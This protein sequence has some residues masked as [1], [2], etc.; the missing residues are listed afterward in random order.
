[1]KGKIAHTQ[2]KVAGTVLGA[3]DGGPAHDFKFNE[4][5]SLSILCKDQAEIDHYWNMITAEGKA[6]QCGW[7]EDPFGVHWQVAP[8]NM[9]EL[10]FDRTNPQEAFQALMGMSKIVIAELEKQEK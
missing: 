3:M 9:K 6:S 1:M 10:L 4:R 2:F 5:I 8:Y 7:C